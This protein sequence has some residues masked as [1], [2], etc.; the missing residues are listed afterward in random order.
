MWSNIPTH[1]ENYRIEDINNRY[2]E[3]DITVKWKY[4]S[5]L[6]QITMYFLD[7]SRNEKE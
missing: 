6:W 7:R 2:M 4:D 3:E 1:S 5:P